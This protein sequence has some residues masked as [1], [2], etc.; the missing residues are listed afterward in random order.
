MRVIILAVLAG[1]ASGCTN[2]YWSRPGATLPVLASES[3]ACYAASLDLDAP[4]ALPG[5]GGQPRLL[6]RST[7]PPR[8]WER[9]P[10]EAAFEHVDEQLQ[11]ARCMRARG[12]R[13]TRIAA[14]LP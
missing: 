7:P 11:Y 14:P 8:L 3:D 1:L 9:A 6:R 2:A 13:P 10:Q 5:P 4:S 12:W